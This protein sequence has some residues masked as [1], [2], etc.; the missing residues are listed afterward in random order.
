MRR[1]TN[2][3]R[4]ATE[5]ICKLDFFGLDLVLFLGEGDQ[6]RL[7]FLFYLSS[8]FKRFDHTFLEMFSLALRNF[9]A[10]L[11]TCKLALQLVNNSLG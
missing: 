10:L 1:K 4:C 2:M 3:S 6:A 8:R 7:G 9:K 5:I 11:H